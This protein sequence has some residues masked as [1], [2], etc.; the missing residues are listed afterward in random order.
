[1]AHWVKNLTAVAQVSAEVRVHSLAHYSRLKGIAAATA[2]VTAVAQLRFSPWP[3]NF[4]MP[5]VQPKKKKKKKRMTK[6][7]LWVTKIKSAK[8]LTLPIEF[9][10]CCYY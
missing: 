7:L 5:Q 4:H 1:M 6:R 9:R 10:C 2:K 3:D 8:H